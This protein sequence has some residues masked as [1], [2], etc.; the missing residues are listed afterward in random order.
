MS[1]R[2][3]RRVRRVRR[4]FT[5]R[6]LATI[7]LTVAA[8]GLAVLAA[9]TVAER[10]SLDES[11]PTIGVIPEEMPDGFPFPPGAAV[12]ESS[13]EGSTATVVL[14]TSG[15][16]FD[17]VSGYTIG[18]VNAGFVVEESAGEGDTWRISFSRGDLRGTIELTP[19][20]IGVESLVTVRQ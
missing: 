18:L 11:G 15:T 3:T 12:G 9:W 17:A 4:F 10:T 1:S 8:A 13:V 5:R 2:F 14:T 20:P 7:V 19:V 16:L 6:T